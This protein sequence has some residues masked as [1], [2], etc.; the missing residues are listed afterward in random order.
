MAER[1]SLADGL[2]AAPPPIDPQKETEFVF[3]GKPAPKAEQHEPPRPAGAPTAGN[4]QARV[5][6]STRMRADLF[7]ALKRASL[8]RQLAG[9]APNTVMDIVEQAVEPWLRTNGYL[10]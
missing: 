2:K 5:P 6:L 3:Q 8:E 1:R 4:G 7:N 10:K 9:Q